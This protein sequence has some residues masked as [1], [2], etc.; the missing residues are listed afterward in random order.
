MLQEQ[1]R[2]SG[3]LDRGSPCHMSIL[4]NANVAGLYRLFMPKSHVKFKKKPNC[5]SIGP[6]SYVAFK[7]RMCHPVDF[8]GQ[9][10]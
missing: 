4:R 5:M 7:K 9:G 10:P 2:T 3:A 6:M 1:T 8:R